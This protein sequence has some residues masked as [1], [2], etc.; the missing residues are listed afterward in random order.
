M[1]K[2]LR[3]V[4]LFAGAVMVAAACGPGGTATTV[5]TSAAT[6]TPATQAPVETGMAGLEGSITLWHSY[7]SSGG[8][9]ESAEVRALNQLIEALTAANPDLEVEAINVPFSDIFTN[10]ETESAAGGGPDMFIAPN[11]NLGNE[12]RGGYLVD[13]TGQIDDVLAETS[14]VAAN[15][16]MVDGVVYMVPESLKAVAMYY[17]SAAVSDPPTTTEELLAFVEGGGKAGVLTR[18]YFGWGWYSAFGGKIFNDDNSCAADDNSGVADALAYV[19]SLNDAGAIVDS[20]YANINDP[21]VAGDL[22]LIFNGNWALGDYRTAREGLAV[23]PFV[24]GPGGA[25]RT[26][27]GV[28]GWYINAAVSDEQQALAIEVAKWLVSAE[29]QQV[30][31]DVAGHVPANENVTSSDALVAAFTDAIYGGDPRPQTAAFGQY[32]GPFD[33]AWDAVVPDD[34]TAEGEDAATAVATACTTMEANIT[35]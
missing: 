9:A 32:W 28:D 17:D 6:T 4:G 10:F 19:A 14:D 13:L 30:M 15:G 31:V 20:N 34:D 5:P 7:G 33:A 3:L 11:D 16:S 2:N 25:G 26:M 1:T 27:T 23:A 35:P 21:F 12:A 22:D 18:A 24:T 8:G 29:S